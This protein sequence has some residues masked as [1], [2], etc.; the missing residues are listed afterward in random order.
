MTLLTGVIY[1]LAVTCIA[2]F[3]MP[4]Q[5]NGSL[6]KVNGKVIG[7]KLIAQKFEDNKYFWPRPSANDYNP[8]SSGGSN[9]GPTSATLQ[10]QVAARTQRLR[11]SAVPAST[12]PL[13]PLLLFASGSGLDPHLNRKGALYQVDRIIKARGLGPKA[14]EEVEILVEMYVNKRFGGVIGR[15][16]V[17]ILLLNLALDDLVKHMNPKAE[18][19]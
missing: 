18:K 7:S 13:P 5:A 3:A 19:K 8:L 2:Q 16:C 10:K 1:P 15:H 9:L 17:N 4:E 12:Y 11:S 14:K 6:V